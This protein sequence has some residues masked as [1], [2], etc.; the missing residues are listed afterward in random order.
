MD[1]RKPVNLLCVSKE[2]V[3]CPLSNCTKHDKIFLNLLRN[4]AANHLG[5]VSIVIIM[6]YVMQLAMN[7]FVLLY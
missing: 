3:F 5:A 4:K 7:I 6:Q 1:N 2:I